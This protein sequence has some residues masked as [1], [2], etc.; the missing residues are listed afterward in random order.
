[1][2]W[3]TSFYDLRDGKGCPIC[4]EGRPAETERGIRIFSGQVCD[5]YLQKARIQRGY[6]VIIWRGRHVAEPTQLTDQEA[7]SYWLE[8]LAVARA[9]EKH[10]R[11]VKTNYDTLGNSLPH[12]HTHLIPRYADD[13]RPGWPFPFPHEP[14]QL[15]DANELRADASALRAL[16][17]RAAPALPR[18]A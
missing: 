9:L 6:T 18:K 12:L 10:L 4:A 17:E 3:P 8:V 11:P 13:P 7:A 14:H 15:R 1:V 16:L 5:A 2:E